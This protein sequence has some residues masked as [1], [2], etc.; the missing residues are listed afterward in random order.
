LDILNPLYTY[1]VKFLL[2]L[3]LPLK[4]AIL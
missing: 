4:T 3:G 1:A 2:I